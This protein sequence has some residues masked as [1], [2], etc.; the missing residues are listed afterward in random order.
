MNG[1]EDLAPIRATLLSGMLAMGLAFGGI[2]L[3][4]GLVPIRTAIIVPAVV[5]D[6]GAPVLVQHV[7]GGRLLQVYVREGQAVAAGA[8][9]ALLDTTELQAERRAIWRQRHEIALRRMVLSALRDGRTGLDAAS[10]PPGGGAG[11]GRDGARCRAALSLFRA[12]NAAQQARLDRVEADR[13]LAAARMDGLVAEQAAATARMTIA[14]EEWARLE[15]LASS[16]QMP[17]SRLTAVSRD[18]AETRLA[19]AGLATAQAEARATLAALQRSRAQT[20]AEAL[21]DAETDLAKIEAEDL[22]LA[23]RLGLLERRI[24]AARLIAPVAGRLAGALPNPGQVL[25]PGEAAFTIIADAGMLRF[26]ARV[27]PGQMP[28]VRVGQQVR[29]KLAALNGAS[30]PELIASVEDW[31]PTALRDDRTGQAYYEVTM[32]ATHP[33]RAPAALFPAM[34]AEA[35]LLGEPRTPLAYLGQALADYFARALREG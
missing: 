29:L 11:A 31:S 28:R 16:G 3:W 2:A 10:C 23:S 32:R 35:F 5:A 18:L 25:A 7:Q 34:P 14:A 8:A 33:I 4:A 17:M 22:D 6:P 9:L 19:V 12:L 26:Q 24:A 13:L 20:L 27:E 21:A 15:P 1:G 30:A